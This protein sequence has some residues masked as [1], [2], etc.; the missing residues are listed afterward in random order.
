M[1]PLAWLPL[2]L[3]IPLIAAGA[4]GGMRP[5]RNTTALAS[6]T[7][8]LA[9]LM[10]A[11]LHAPE[12]LGG[13]VL[14]WSV[15]WYPALGLA[16]SLRMDALAWLLVVLV[17]GVGALVVLYAHYYLAAEDATPTFYSRLLV[18]AAAMIG[19]AI[20][21]NL[22]LLVVFW[23]LT[24]LASYLLIAH[25]S[26]RSDARAG[27]RMSLAITAGGGLA[28]LGGVLLIGAVVGS[29][30]LDQV[31]VAG[32][33]LRADPR[34]P[35][36]LGLV[37]LGA[38]TKSAQFPFHFWLPQ[39]MAA[40][41]PVS[42]FLHSATLV[43]AGVFLLLRLYP[44]LS[45]TPEWL[46]LVAGAGLVTLL[47]GAWSA[48]FQHDLKGLLA[49][50]T[51]SHLGLITLLIGLESPLTTVA[52]VFH[53]LNHATFKA[54]L[55]MAAG[56]IDHECGTR[57]MRRL[58]GLMRHLPWTGSLAI[59]AAAAMAGVPLLNGFL[60]K[61]MFFAE[62]LAV[63]EP[64]WLAWLVPAGALLAGVFGVAYSTR[65]IHDVFFG[66]AI[67]ELSHTPH[68]PPRWMKVP[69]EV[70]VL[71]CIA[72]GSFPAWTIGA[73]LH[74]VATA[75]HGAALPEYSLAIWH[76]FNLPLLMSA[77]AF[78]LGLALYFAIY[79]RGALHRW[80]PAMPAAGAF[81]ASLR[82]VQWLAHRCA[83]WLA[84]GTSTQLRL[85]LA[86]AVL[87][88]LAAW[89]QVVAAP[90][91][92]PAPTAGLLAWLL[93]LS[94]ALSLVALLAGYRQRV[95]TVILLGMIGLIVSACFAI[96]SAPD[97]ALTQLLVEVASVLLL[98]LALRR[99]PLVAAPESGRA[100]KLRDG[101][102]A[103][104]CG[105]GVAFLCHTV[106]MQP[107]DPVSPWF[108][109]HALTLAGGTNVVNVIIVD[110]RG[111]DTL[112]E[113]TVF[114]IAVLVVG[115]LLAGPDL[116]PAV[117]VDERDHPLLLRTAAT[118]L[119]PFA[120]L[121]SL[122]F[123]L[124]GHNQP[125]GGF[126]AGLVAAGAI[127]FHL[128]AHGRGRFE[129]QLRWPWQGLLVTGL[130]L[131][132]GTGAAAWLAGYPFL[133]SYYQYAELPVIGKL[134]LAS[135]FVFDLGVCLVVAGGTVLAL[136]ALASRVD[137]EREAAWTS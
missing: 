116:H 40:P 44:A 4:L 60:S 104:A 58:H 7:A 38:F 26:D 122:H 67:S 11:L 29:F 55:F 102:I 48:I 130:L 79:Q 76:G 83:G 99:L 134:P 95:R 9:V 23:E 54:S 24:S 100:R 73:A 72:V 89:F 77:L 74:A 91:A 65:F 51:V 50:S 68:E 125:G 127:A 118:W 31:L 135:V 94:L 20:S 13:K 18:F 105:A 121:F 36:I 137:G 25:W 107:H 136:M 8:L 32:D 66:R 101:L 43:K 110:F 15:D 57:D 5:A 85:L 109:E 96:L 126:I 106:L 103:V 98:L 35:W 129:A 52:A 81:A 21:G 115:G 90:A 120:L 62:T 88:A 37:L 19:V 119:L 80:N 78:V 17:S 2:M 16:F 59:V 112:G 133:T 114:A 42:A 56:I 3:A 47:V 34:Y 113:M 33:Q 117:S 82:A 123:L 53:L 84:P 86:T 61:E 124:R 75:A 46:Y 27:A 92:P 6:G 41:T 12:V 30:E 10:L 128:L 39:A 1:P 22:L 97:L 70:L 131:A 14:R 63:S 132:V 71:L 69:V 45:G 87:I 28:L 93:F 64:A 49:Y 111:L 108:L